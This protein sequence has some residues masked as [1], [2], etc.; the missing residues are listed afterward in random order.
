[1]KLEYKDTRI[2]GYKNTKIYQDTGYNR[3]SGY[4]RILE[5]KDTRIKV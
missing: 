3:M 1:M 4:I 5:C 2:Q